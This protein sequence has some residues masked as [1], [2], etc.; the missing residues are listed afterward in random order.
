M[1]KKFMRKGFILNII[2][3]FALGIFTVFLEK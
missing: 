2:F 3:L 1:D